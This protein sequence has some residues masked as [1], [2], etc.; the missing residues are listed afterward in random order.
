MQRTDRHGL[1]LLTAIKPNEGKQTQGWLQARAKPHFPTSLTAK[2]QTL[3][4]GLIHKRKIQDK[5][6]SAP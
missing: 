3:S 1:Q 4:H 6:N 2:C 5:S